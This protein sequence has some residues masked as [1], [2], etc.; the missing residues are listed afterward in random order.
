[1]EFYCGQIGRKN[2][3]KLYNCIFNKANLN[4]LHCT[5]AECSKS[6]RKHNE[7]CTRLKPWGNPEQSAQPRHSKGAL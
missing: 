1:M 2:K 5:K 4:Q 7:L 6:E 3:N